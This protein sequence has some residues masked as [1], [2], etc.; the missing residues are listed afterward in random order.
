MHGHLSRIFH[1][2]AQARK[3][4]AGD[5]Q[6]WPKE[7]TTIRFKE[8]LRAETIP[9]RLTSLPDLTFNEVLAG[10]SSQ[11]DFS[12]S[13]TITFDELSTLLHF[14][15]GIRNPE[16]P[17]S[18]GLRYYPSPGPRYPLEVYVC[19]KDVTGLKA[20]IYHYNVRKDALE[21]I[22]GD[23]EIAE[24]E[25]A[26][27]YPWARKAPAFLITTSVWDRNFMKYRDFG[28]RAVL[29]EAGY[30]GQNVL[31]VGSLLGMKMCP[32]L[33][34]DNAELESAIS[35]TEDDEDSLLV[36]LIGI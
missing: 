6:Y 23:K 3:V 18:Q 17:S 12:L 15:S 4:P 22:G 21:K 32:L 30:H 36:T 10:R 24:A 8:Y 14:S 7:W 28:Y 19:V 33:G 35:I 29:L 13:E 9:L 20:G 16:E 2:Q 26:L 34:F 1:R 11:R 5:P 25:Q 31:L 27:L